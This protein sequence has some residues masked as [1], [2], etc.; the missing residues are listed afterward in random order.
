MHFYLHMSIFF[1]TFAAAKVKV[2]FTN[3]EIDKMNIVL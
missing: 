2:A 3:N 1:R